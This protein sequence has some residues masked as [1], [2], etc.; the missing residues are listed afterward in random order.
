MERTT[1]QEHLSD[2]ELFAL[3]A[4]ATG[5][6]EALPR[7]LSHCQTCSRALQEWKAAVR[8]L[9]EEEVGELNRRS[10]T[11]WRAAEDATMAAILRSSKPHRLRRPLRWAI[12]IAASLLIVALAMPRRSVAP[13]SAGLAASSEEPALSDA[14]R[15]DDRLLR[16]VSFLAQGDDTSSSL[17]VE[18]SL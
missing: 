13:A 1:S 12:G 3:A 9:A 4:P 10:S 14:D 2:A 11:E 16:D 17:L 7:H 5:E 15:E 6:P 8:A 18:E